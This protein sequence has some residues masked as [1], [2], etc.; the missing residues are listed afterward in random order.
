MTIRKRAETIDQVFEEF[1]ADQKARLSPK[2]Y[3]RY[4]D[5]I[6]LFRAYLERYW[7]GRASY[8][9]NPSRRTIARLAPSQYLPKSAADVRWAGTSAGSP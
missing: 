3:R 7:P 4:D 2:T 8:G 1:L 9:W 5:I 6:D